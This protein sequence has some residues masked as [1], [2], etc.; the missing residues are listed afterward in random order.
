MV[1][2][3]FFPLASRNAP[4]LQTN[5]TPKWSTRTESQPCGSWQG[6]SQPPDIHTVHEGRPQSNVWICNVIACV[7]VYIYISMLLRGDAVPSLLHICI[8]IYIHTYTYSHDNTPFLT[9]TSRSG[10]CRQAPP[11]WASSRAQTQPST[12]RSLVTRCA[13]KVDTCGCHS[14]LML[15]IHYL[16]ERH[17]EKGHP[18]HMSTWFG[19]QSLL[20]SQVLSGSGFFFSSSSSMSRPSLVVLFSFLPSNSFSCWVAYSS[21]GSTMYLTTTRVFEVCVGRNIQV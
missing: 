10:P 1:F 8:Y 20:G 5:R 13:A 3:E 19:T 14:Q 21:M 7:N 2:C 15:G 12:L 16:Y 4:C 6:P 18:G 11:S 9:V 17:K